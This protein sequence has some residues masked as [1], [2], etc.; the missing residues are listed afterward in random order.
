MEWILNLLKTYACKGSI[1]KAL[2]GIIRLKK[3][4]QGFDVVENNQTNNSY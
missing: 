3:S 2:P 1:A 4:A